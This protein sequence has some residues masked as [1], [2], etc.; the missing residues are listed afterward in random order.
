MHQALAVF[1]P[2]R[3]RLHR[4]VIKVLLIQTSTNKKRCVL[5]AF[6]G[7]SMRVTLRLNPNR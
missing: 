3:S 5:R 7:G 1:A 4:G 6:Y 2:L